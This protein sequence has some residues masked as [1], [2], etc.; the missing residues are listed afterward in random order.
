MIKHGWIV[1]KL[2]KLIPHLRYF[3]VLSWFED[4]LSKASDLR[5]VLTVQSRKFQNKAVL[6]DDLF[7]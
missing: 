4:W 5:D 1:T 2:D 3:D 6:V 7:G